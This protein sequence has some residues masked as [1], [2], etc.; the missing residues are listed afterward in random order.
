[1]R[2]FGEGHALRLIT[3]GNADRF[4]IALGEAGLAEATVRR[5]IGIAKQFFQAAE[6][7]EIIAKKPFGDLVVAVPPNPERAFFVDRPTIERVLVAM[8]DPEWRLLIGLAR[9]GRLRVP[10]RSRSPG[11]M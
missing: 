6:R 7:S 4:R 10:N 9:F 2:F 3:A 1:V 5:T 11:A 8:D